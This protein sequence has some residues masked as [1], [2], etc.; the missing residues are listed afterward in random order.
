MGRATAI[1]AAA[2]GAKVVLAARSVGALEEVAATIADASGSATVVPTDATDRAQV[3]QLFERALAEHG[4]VDAVV[5]ATGANIKARAIDQLTPQSWSEL[6]D[7]NLT[8]GFHV[9]QAVLPIFRQQKDGLLIYLSS[10]S[11]LTGDVS[12]VAYQ[13]AKRGIVG[14]AHGTMVEE[15]V[16]GIRTT[17]IFPGLTDTPLLLQRPVVPTA[18]QLAVALQPEDVS[19]ACLLVLGLPPRAHVPELVLL[20]TVRG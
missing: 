3:D 13:A 2:A 19:E 15:R 7:A 10:G 16:N 5:H 4:R 1:A 18:E 11:A 8:A 17:V 14:L 6:V 20:P 9:T 12:G